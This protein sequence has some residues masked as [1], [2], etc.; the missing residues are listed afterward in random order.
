MFRSI[1]FQVNWA[2]ATTAAVHLIKPHGVSRDYVRQGPRA[3]LHISVGITPDILTFPAP[4]TDR[5][6][7][8]PAVVF[9][10]QRNG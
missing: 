5:R 10:I 9:E 3:R 4:S 1:S 2:L 8:T 7:C 6:E